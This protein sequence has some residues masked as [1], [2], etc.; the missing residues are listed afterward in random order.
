VQYR[1]PETSQVLAGGYFDDF[2]N[3]LAN[4]TVYQE[5]EAGGN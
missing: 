3:D 5:G 2:E 1:M 4:W